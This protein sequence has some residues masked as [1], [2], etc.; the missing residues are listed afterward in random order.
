MVAALAHGA[1][2][3]VP[4]LDEAAAQGNRG[5][6]NVARRYASHRGVA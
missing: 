4:V 2:E 5:V 6:R 1:L 3:V